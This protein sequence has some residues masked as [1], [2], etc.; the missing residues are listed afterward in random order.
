MEPSPARRNLRILLFQA[1]EI[2]QAMPEIF[3]LWKQS[4]HHPNVET[5]SRLYRRRF[6]RS[7]IRWN[8]LDDIYLRLCE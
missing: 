1:L 2:W 4:V 8:P 3:R 7:T 5:R 6:A